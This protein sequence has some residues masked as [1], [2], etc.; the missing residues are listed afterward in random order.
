MTLR[1]LSISGGKPIRLKQILRDAGIPLS[2]LAT[3]LGISRTA[4]SLLVNHGVMP[5]SAAEKALEPRIEQ[6]LANQIS[7]NDDTW[8]AEEVEPACS[9]TPA[10]DSP[11]QDPVDEPNDEETATMLLRKHRLTQA[12]RQHFELAANPFGDVE[13]IADV[14]LS[15]DI[16]YA[17]EALFDAAM[18]NQFVAVIGESGAGKSTLREELIDRLQREKR[19]VHVIEPAVLAMAETDS[20]GKPLRAQHI[21]EAIMGT[22]APLAPMRS[23][24]QARFEQLKKTLIESHRAGMR[25]LILIEEAHAMPTSTLNHLKRF[26][27]IKDGLRKVLGIAL[28]GQPE[29]A[30]KLSESNPQVREV[31]QRVEIVTLPPLDANLDAYLKH[32]FERAGLPV[33][34]VLEGSAI[35]ALRERLAPSRQRGMS[36]L[37]PQ[38]VHNVLA[39]AMNMAAELGMPRVN[40]DVIR[41]V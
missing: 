21:A 25:H 26:L 16:R 20:K 8:K 29:L 39:R 3:H 37:Y 13:D 33:A 31:V 1:Q 18:H 4:V 22:V 17:R 35:D 41:G 30:I 32:R 40:A 15:P 36:L 24:P 23:S 28:L 2:E 34:R 38:A 5:A 11:T 12:T 7:S 10:P 19:D 14:F 27:E 6:F 9:N